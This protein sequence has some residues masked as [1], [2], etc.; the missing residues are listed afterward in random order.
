[1]VNVEKVRNMGAAKG[2]SGRV[3]NGGVGSVLVVVSSRAEARRRIFFKTAEHQFHVPRDAAGFQR[4]I[5]EGA[6]S[7][8]EG[9][10]VNTARRS[11]PTYLS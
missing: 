5:G 10:A 9:G 7:N 1:M 4:A 3:G 2:L 6:V 11:C 8:P